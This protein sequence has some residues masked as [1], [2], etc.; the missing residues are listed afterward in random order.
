MLVTQTWREVVSVLPRFRIMAVSMKRLQIR[1]AR[2]AVLAIDMV[3]LDAVVM[4]EVQPTVTTPAPLRFEQPCQFGTD[5]W[6]PSLSCAPVHPIAIVRTAIALDFDMSHNRYLAVSPKARRVRV[7]RRGGKGQACAQSMPVAPGDPSDRCA[8]MSPACPGSELDP[9]E[10]IEPIV[11]GLTHTGAVV[12]G[13]TPDFGVE[14]ANHQALRP[15]STAFD[16]SPKLR[17]M[18]RHIGLGGFDQGFV[19]EASMASGAFTRLVFVH[20]ILPDVEPQERKPGLIAFQG[21]ANATFG[22]V[23]TQSHRGQPGLEQLLSVFKHPAV[24][25]QHHAIIGVS[26]NSGLRV[27]LGDGLL[28]P[29]EGNQRQQR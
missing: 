20:P 2:I 23:Q 7:R 8:R 5:H 12:S 17:Q 9:G 4:L 19:P 26:D 28:H 29:M 6:M 25:V 10:M 22:F 21:M 3:H 27:E 14:L 15:G 18:V 11:D 16:D 1:R 13:P 24:L